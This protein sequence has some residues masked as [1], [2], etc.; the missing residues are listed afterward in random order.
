MTIA[1][2]FSAV[3]GASHC[4]N[5]PST[6]PTRHQEIGRSESRQYGMAG[7]ITSS[8]WEGLYLADELVTEP[9]VEE[10][11]L[12]DSELERFLNSL[13]HGE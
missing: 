8:P 9:A 6:G 7:N 10:S 5:L 11:T 2:A 1:R 12:T 4:R 13:M 3:F